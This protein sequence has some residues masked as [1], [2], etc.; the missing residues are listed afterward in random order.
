M[1]QGG[2]YKLE[3]AEGGTS[4]VLLLERPPKNHLIHNSNPMLRAIS[5]HLSRSDFVVPLTKREDTNR[6]TV[7]DIRRDG[8]SDTVNLCC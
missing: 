3:T 7:G 5:H 1:T 6:E 4:L 2:T 8:D